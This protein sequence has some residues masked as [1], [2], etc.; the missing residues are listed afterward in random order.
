MPPTSRSGVQNAVLRERLTGDSVAHDHRP[1]TQQQSAEPPKLNL[2]ALIDPPTYLTIDFREV[3]ALG[4][5]LLALELGPIHY[6]DQLVKWHEATQE[7]FT[8]TPNWTIETP[9][10]FSFYTDGSSAYLDDE[11]KAA[12]AVVL[13]NHPHP[14]RRPIWW[15]PQ[16]R[17]GARCICPA[18]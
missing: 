8:L 4:S 15:I 7:A 2:A 10:G 3:Q 11:R 6:A 5:E 13:I 16:L 12:A 9:I 1:R 17:S 14:P 18:S